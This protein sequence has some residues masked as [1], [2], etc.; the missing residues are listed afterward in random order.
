MPDK[1]GIDA[2]CCAWLPA[3]P[4]G[5]GACAK[6][7]IVAGIAATV[8]A[9]TKRTKLRCMSI[10]QLPLMRVARRNPTGALFIRYSLMNA[11]TIGHFCCGR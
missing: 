8:A 4:P 9:A 10:G 2:E 6:V 11:P 1:F 7:G 5:E 3:G